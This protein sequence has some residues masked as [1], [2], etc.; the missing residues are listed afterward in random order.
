MNDTTFHSLSLFPKRTRA[1]AKSAAGGLKKH[2]RVV[3][4]S[5][6]ARES[7]LSFSL[8]SLGGFLRTQRDVTIRSSSQNPRA[9]G[10]KISNDDSYT[11]RTFFILDL[12]FHVIDGIRRLHFQG[13]GF[14]RQGFHEN[15]HLLLLRLVYINIYVCDLCSLCA[16]A[17]VRNF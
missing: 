17:F 9:R 5:P 1:R 8:S 16:C 2:K 12:R 11:K 15:L 6:R 4:F 7:A 10:G 13:D 3:L 14:A